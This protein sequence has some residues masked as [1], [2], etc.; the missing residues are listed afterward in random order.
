MKTPELDPNLQKFLRCGPVLK[1]Y[2]VLIFKGV[3]I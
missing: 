2:E 3:R 1:C